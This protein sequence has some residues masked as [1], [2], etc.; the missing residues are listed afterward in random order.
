MIEE[1]IKTKEVPE[2]TIFITTEAYT[3]MR[4][5]VNT[6]DT[7]V[8][9]YGFVTKVPGLPNDV[10]YYVIEDIVVYPQKVTGATVEQDDDKMFD[11]EMSLTTEQVNMKRFQGHS[12][13]NMGTTPSGVDEQF[14][15]DL[16]TQVTDF[17]IILINNKS[18][19]IYLRFY[20]K[21]NNIV[22]NGLELKVLLANG[23]ST[24]QW[25]DT[26]KDM[27]KKPVTEV[28]SYASWPTSYDKYK[29]KEDKKKRGRPKKEVTPTY[30]QY[31]ID[32][33]PYLDYIPTIHEQ[34][35]MLKSKYD[36]GLIS[37][38]EYEQELDEIWDRVW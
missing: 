20:D 8:G 29:D 19:S 18:N 21:E 23:L 4:T 31:E 36:R 24:D 15:Q 27:I 5:L 14:Y 11:F 25:Y 34:E 38:E 26:V 32:D 2:P 9:W 28:K 10:R 12:H 22:Y 30:K 17:F 16:L 3:K 13:V 7:E 35:K 33:D 6:T 1:H 37:K